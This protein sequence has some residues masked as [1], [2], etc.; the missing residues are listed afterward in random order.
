M[1]SM[2]IYSRK[3]D[4]IELLREISRDHVADLFDEQLEV[5]VVDVW[6]EGILQ[7]IDN[8]DLAFVDITDESG[9][10]IAKELRNRFSKIE[11]M[12]ISDNTISPVVYLTPDIRAA[13]LLLKP[14]KYNESKNGIKG[15][16][17]L[18]QQNMNDSESFFLFEDEK[19]QKRI[20]YSQI[21][22]FEA[23]NGR[24]YVRLQN[25]EYGMYKT[26]KTLEEELP[27]NFKRCHKSFI[28]NMAYISKI[29]YSKNIIILNNDLE[30]PVSRS[31]KNII[32]EVV[33]SG[34]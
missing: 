1:I 33:K 27:E 34:K 5:I 6:K 16:F 15:I 3:Q 18:L 14:L 12:I 20:P 4:E 25:K 31:Y 10:R 17:H 9:L 7:K 24:I 2:L 29:W 28:V 8:I 21:L 19:E 30:I 32:K 23:R 26:I 11:I 22:Y 13:S